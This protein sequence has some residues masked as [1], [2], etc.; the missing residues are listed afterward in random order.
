MSEFEP[1]F[2]RQAAPTIIRPS[3]AQRPSRSEELTIAMGDAQIGFR[4]EEPFHDER[5]MRLATLACRELK[6][7][8]IVL[9]GDMLDLPAMSR[10]EQRYDWQHRTQEAIDRYHNFLAQ[11]R[12]DNPNADITAVGG[13]HEERMLKSTRDNAAEILGLTRANAQRALGVLTVPFLVRYDDLEV[14]NVDG[15]PNGAY[16]LEDNLKVIH[17]TATRK[18]GSNAATYLNREVTSTVYGHSHRIE[19]AYRTLPTKAGQGSTI[20][21]ASPGC[22]ARTDGAVPGRNYSVDSENRTVLRSE[23]WQQGLLIIEHDK[24]NHN[25]T[26]VRFDESGMS[27]WGKRYE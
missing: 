8:H 19:L 3:R 15:Y 7:D 2:I 1:D 16:W 10:Y 26:P 14:N 13:N 4:G 17:G 22:L 23:D 6:P 9:T 11:L 24:N 25:I 12:A 21:A 5:A 18:G 27:I 20:A